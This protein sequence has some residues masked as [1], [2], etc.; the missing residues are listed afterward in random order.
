M[1]VTK[2]AD[3]AA[4]MAIG[5]Y[6]ELPD[7]G[8]NDPDFRRLDAWGADGRFIYFTGPDGVA[9]LEHSD[10]KITVTKL[11]FA[12]DGSRVDTV[13]Y[14]ADLSVYALAVKD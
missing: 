5:T 1:I 3:V 14:Q 9:E 4:A 10:G 11:G 2:P 12:A 13:I 6:P 8:D 7:I